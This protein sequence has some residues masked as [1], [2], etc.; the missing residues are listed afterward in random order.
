[1]PVDWSLEEVEATVADY[2]DM[3][4]RE[5]AGIDYSKTEHRRRLSELLNGRSDAAIERKHQNITAALNHLNCGGIVGYKPL[6]NYQHLL[7]AT[8][9]DWIERHPGLA[10]AMT[11]HAS[12]PAT[13]PTMD[14]IMAA[15]VPPP[16]PVPLRNP[17]APALVRESLTGYGT[18]YLGKEAANMSLGNAGEEF[19][20]GFERQRLLRSGKDRLASRIVHVSKDRGD[21]EGFDILSFDET[22]RERLI[23]VKT[24]AYGEYTPFFVTRH[25]LETSLKSADRYY[26]YRLHQFRL[27][28]KLYMKPGPLDQSFSLDPSQFLARV[29]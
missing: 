28:P 10:R 19:V 16:K 18:D 5:I 13:L 4:E 12:R 7:F 24:T 14:D 8:V 17:A 1:M 27:K 25:E 21:S 15:L 9:A 11:F 2:F 22:G 20:L 26:L 6:P 29:A 23:E 3:F